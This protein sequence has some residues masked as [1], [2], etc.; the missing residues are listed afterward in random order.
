MSRGSS[1]RPRGSGGR[2]SSLPLAPACSPLALSPSVEQAEQRRQPDDQYHR[3]DQHL[4]QREAVL[5]SEVGEAGRPAPGPLSRPTGE[6]GHGYEHARLWV[7]STSDAPC[8]S[9]LVAFTPI[10]GV[11]G[12]AAEPARQRL[13]L[14]APVGDWC[15]G[16]TV[17][18]KT[19][20]PGSIPGSPAWL[21]S[22]ESR[23][24]RGIPAPGTRSPSSARDR[25]Q[26]LEKWPN[27]PATGR[28]SR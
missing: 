16:N 13:Q 6:C 12:A 15:I 20:T 5:A 11:T 2:G 7:F 17:V 18:S 1:A 25:S 26:P 23:S 10:R 21:Y 14:R 28:L 19:A 9:A 8:F 27:R 22:A 24:R 4:E 3:R